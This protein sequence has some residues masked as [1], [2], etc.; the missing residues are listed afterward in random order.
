MDFGQTTRTACFVLPVSY[1]TRSMGKRDKLDFTIGVIPQGLQI[2]DF[3]SIFFKY[4]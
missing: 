4:L 3:M 2:L 1:S